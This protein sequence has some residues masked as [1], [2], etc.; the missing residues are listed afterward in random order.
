MGTTRSNSSHQLGAINSLVVVVGSLVGL[1]ASAGLLEAELNHLRNPAAQLG[2]DLNSLIGCGASLMSPEAHL[3]VIPNSA[4]GM[5]AFAAMTM[6][7]VLMLV[8]AQFPCFI[9][10]LAALGSIGGLAFVGFFLYKSATLFNALCPYCLV[11]WSAA[12]VLAGVLIPHGLANI[13]ATSETGKVLE[14]YSW[15]VILALHL[16][17][18]IIVLLTMSDQIGALL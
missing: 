6:L 8:K 4:L 1:F 13:P 7:G 12:M 3:L 16:I 10:Y 5:A 2:C 11:V 9:S 14:R 17:V 15:L 18:V